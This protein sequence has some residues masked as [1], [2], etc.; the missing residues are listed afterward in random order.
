MLFI[1]LSIYL[2]LTILSLLYTKK[3]SL[4]KNVDVIVILSA[5]SD[6]ITKQRIELGINVAS[7]YSNSKILF[8]GKGKTDLF[9][10]DIKN[11]S[12]TYFINKDSTN[13]YEDAFL[14]KKYLGSIQSII[15]VTSSSHQRRAM[16]TFSRVYKNLKIYNYPTNDFLT[17]YSPF[18]PS[19][20]AAV[21]INL[22]KDYEYN[23]GK[24]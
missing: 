23:K 2:C 22:L 9:T 19:G 10:K 12:N 4:P 5:S 20:W 17:P 1:L 18:L 11:F 16:H 8:C 24:N 7:K 21:L 6:A 3:D 13:T 15:L 14:S